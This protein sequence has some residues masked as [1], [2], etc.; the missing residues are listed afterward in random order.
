VALEAAILGKRGLVFG[1][2]W[3]D[4]C[5]NLLR[6]TRD[7]SWESFFTAPISD[8]KKIGDW[9]CDKLDA[10]G[11]PGCVN[12]SNEKYFLTYYADGSLSK[13]EAVILADAVAAA[14]VQGKPVV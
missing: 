1:G 4:G 10:C 11:L 13:C 6:F 2:A 12:P 5:P 7:L 9:L 3:F 8:S 14:L